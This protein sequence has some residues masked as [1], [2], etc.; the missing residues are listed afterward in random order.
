LKSEWK[1]YIPSGEVELT[2][3]LSP[4]AEARKGDAPNSRSQEM[5]CERMTHRSKK[6]L[7]S[8]DD[9]WEKYSEVDLR[10]KMK[11]GGKVQGSKDAEARRKRV[12]ISDCHF[13]PARVRSDFNV[14]AC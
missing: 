6:Q 10:N 11:G 5:V 12:Q 1:R 7:D 4:C 8:R 3:L 2:L 13:P 14:F 9:S